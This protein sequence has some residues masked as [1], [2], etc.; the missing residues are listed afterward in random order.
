M[1]RPTTTK[2]G[3]SV[4]ISSK[5]APFK[6]GQVSVE[7]PDINSLT[8]VNP[9]PLWTRVYIGPWL[10]FYPLAYYAWLNYDTYIKSIGEVSTISLSL[11]LFLSRSIE[12]IQD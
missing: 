8:L 1:A 10:L 11:S 3:G 9:L 12:L 2:G 6:R 4:A 7:S 5:N